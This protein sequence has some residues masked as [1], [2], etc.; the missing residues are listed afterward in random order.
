MTDASRIQIH[1][2]D[3]FGIDPKVLEYYG[4]FNVSLINDLP[5]FIDPFLLF[6]ST[7]A[8]Y[9]QLHDDIIEYLGFLKN[10]SLA[11]TIDPGLLRAWFT[12][13]EV[14][15]NW[16]GYSLVGN[17]GLGL[18]MDF[19]RSL[20]RNLHTIFANFGEEHIARGSHLEKLC[21]IDP[22][23]GRDNISDFTT[24]LMK[25]FLLK[26]TQTFAQ[27]HIHE[28][29]RKD[30]RIEKVRF[31][32]QTVSWQSGTFDLPWYDVEDD[33]VVLTPKD[34]LTKDEAW[35]SRSD[36][37]GQFHNILSA[38]P[39][40]Q[41]RA[42]INYYFLSRLPKEPERQDRERAVAASLREFPVL[43]EYYIRL[44]EDHG[45]EAVAV[46]NLR[47]SQTETLFVRKVGDLTSQLAL[48]TQFYHVPGNTYEEARVRVFFLKDVIENK[49]GHDIFYIGSDPIRKE[50][51]LHIL[52]RLC[53]L[54][55]PSDVSREVNDG[56]G[57]ADYKISR[58]AFDKTI[59]EFK[60]ASNRQLKRNLQKQVDIYQKA[61]DAHKALKVIVYFTEAELER[62]RRILADLGLAHADNVILID[63]RK[64]NKPSGSKA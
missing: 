31:N 36:L 6:N 43:I 41:L 16:F 26:Y 12:F 62:V 48:H 59:V 4:A 63:A 56:R 14:K 55:T 42:Q 1:F 13:P 24:N 29:L 20:H 35:I 7:D 15:Q 17:A 10:R 38:I 39:N 40:D 19:A 23:V 51:D 58:G 34:L 22:G 49:G 44:R 8:T 61:S 60:L 54:G 21:L 9:Q 2:S 53:W 32:Y 28:S 37:H 47:V 11:G 30:V 64:D 5:L 57:P 45:E 46:S 33:F 50:S 27:N 3:F 52:F 18:G 25:E